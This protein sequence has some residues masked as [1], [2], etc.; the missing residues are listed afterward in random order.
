MDLI[1]GFRYFQL[2]LYIHRTIFALRALIGL[3]RFGVSG[4]TGG[5]GGD[6]SSYES[7]GSYLQLERVVENAFTG[8]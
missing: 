3:R 7:T 4:A 1:D 8:S 2:D 6:V 5:R